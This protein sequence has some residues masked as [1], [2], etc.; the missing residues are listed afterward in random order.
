M[1]WA[2]LIPIIGSVLD[3]VIPDATQA[4]DAKLK[5]LELVQKGELTVLNA[6]VELAKGQMAINV[7]DAKSNDIF[8]GG[9]RPAAGWVCVAGLFYQVLLQPILPWVVQL[10][11]V[12]PLPPLP[13]IDNETLFTLLMGMLGL[14]G[15]RT[16]ERV[17]GR[18]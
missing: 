17:K 13:L 9:W 18:V 11:A 10:F 7:E 6:E 12:Q 3:K 4:S 8:R 2:A 5:L 1:S 16:F 15:F 14:G